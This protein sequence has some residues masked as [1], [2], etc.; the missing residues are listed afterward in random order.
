MLQV[1]KKLR[2]FVSGF[3]PI[4]RPFGAHLKVRLFDR[5]TSVHQP[6][7][8]TQ[9]LTIDIFN[10]C[11][12]PFIVKWEFCGCTAYRVMDRCSA[13]GND[14]FG[15][16]VESLYEATQNEEIFEQIWERKSGGCPLCT[17]TI[18]VELPKGSLEPVTHTGTNREVP[19]RRRRSTTFA[20][21][22]RILIEALEKNSLLTVT[23]QPPSAVVVVVLKCS[24]LAVVD[25]AV[26]LVGGRVKAA[27]RDGVRPETA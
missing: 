16:C 27:Y 23:E 2:L 22:A 13:A 8:T 11:L 1:M 26:V 3:D 4:E 12:V 17:N 20:A 9:H 15:I 19:P 5:W 7:K 14:L 18:Y 21:L 24:E 10:M 6:H 25:V